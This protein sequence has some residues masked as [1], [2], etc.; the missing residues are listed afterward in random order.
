MPYESL[1]PFIIMGTMLALMG[2]IPSFLHKTVYGKPKPVMQDAFDYALAE[3]DRRV[4]EEAH[5]ESPIKH[6]PIST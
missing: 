1:P 5:V 2:A 3:R 4:L 6:G